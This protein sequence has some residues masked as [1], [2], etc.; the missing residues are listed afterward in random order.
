MSKSGAGHVVF[1]IGARNSDDRNIVWLDRSSSVIGSLQW[2]L[3]PMTDPCCQK[4]VMSLTYPYRF[5]DSVNPLEPSMAKMEELTLE[6]IVG[7][8][9]PTFVACASPLPAGSTP[10]P[11]PRTGQTIGPIGQDDDILET[12]I[13]WPEPRFTNHSNGT[14]TDNSNVSIADRSR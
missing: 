6:T 1:L 2:T 14:V 13:A 9:K 7:V 5:K 11:V 4:L 3:T 10:A 12:G 8:V